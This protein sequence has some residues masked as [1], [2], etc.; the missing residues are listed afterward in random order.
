[1]P[2]RRSPID[3]PPVSDLRDLPTRFALAGSD[4]PYAPGGTDEPDR[5]PEPA[6]LTI[7]EVAARLRMSEKSIRRRIKDGV[8]HTAPTGG[9]LVRIS[10]NELVR[11]TAGNPPLDP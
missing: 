6:L 9:R 4:D 1:M 5:R 2:R 7:S 10:S 8:I 11:L 3:L